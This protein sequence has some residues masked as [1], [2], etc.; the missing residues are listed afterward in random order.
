MH[1]AVA[2]FNKCKKSLLSMSGASRSDHIIKSPTVPPPSRPDHIKGP[3]HNK[4]QPPAQPSNN[5]ESKKFKDAWVPQEIQNIYKLLR[6]L[7]E[8]RGKCGIELEKNNDNRF[9]VTPL[10]DDENLDN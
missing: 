8:D 1:F 5:N 3:L 4:H 6:F 10:L 7:I 9:F 2:D